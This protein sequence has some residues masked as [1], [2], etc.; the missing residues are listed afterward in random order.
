[1]AAL[2]IEAGRTGIAGGAIEVVV[3]V[4]VVGPA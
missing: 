1:M 4:V 2:L 3:V